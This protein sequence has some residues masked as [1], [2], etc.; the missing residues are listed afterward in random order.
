MKIEFYNKSNNTSVTYKQYEG[1]YY[2]VDREGD[3][4]RDNEET[5]ESQSM[6]VYL[7]TFMEKCPDIGWR[8]VE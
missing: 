7:E 1:P 4:Y 8:V 3:V 2:F 5:Y 6:V